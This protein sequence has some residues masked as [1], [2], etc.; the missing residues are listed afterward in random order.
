MEGDSVTVEELKRQLSTVVEHFDREEFL[1]RSQQ[2]RLWKKLKYYWD[3]I[4][5]IYWDSV[6]HDWRFFPEDQYNFN[7]Y[8]EKNVNVFRAYLESII[9]ALSVSVP[10]IICAPDDA[11]NPLDLDTA[12]AGNKIAELVSKHNDVI[13]LWIHALFI[14]CT[15][16]MVACYNYTKEDEA[17]GMVEIPKRETGE[18][19]QKVM[20]CPNCKNDIPDP[21]LTALEKDEYDPGEED[22]DVQNL[23]MND[24]ILCKECLELVDPEY[25]TDKIIV[26]RIVG[27][28]QEP[29]ARQCLEVYGGLYVKVPNWARKQE[30]IPYLIWSYETHY[31][32]VLARYPDLWDKKDGKP[33][34]A[35]SGSSAYDQ[36][37]KWGRQSPQ[38]AGDIPLKDTVTV[39]NCWLRPSAFYILKDNN[40]V[41][42]LEKKFPNGVYV[43]KINDTVVDYRNESLDDHWTLTYNPLSD[44]IHHDPLGMLLT[45]IQ[46]ITSELVNLTIQT[47]EHGIPQTFVDPQVLD[48]NK[49]SQT[50]VQPGSLYPIKKTP[51]SGNIGDAF[52][53]IKTA[54]LSGEVLPFMEKIQEAGQLV[55]GAVPSIFGGQASGGSKTAAVY[56]MSRAQA[57]QRLQT[58]WK[59]LSFWWKNVFS[60]VI[61]AF[62]KDMKDDERFVA[63]DKTGNYLNVFIRKST[64]EAGKIGSIEL[65]ASEQLPATWAQKK[66]VIMQLLQGNNPMVMQALM[67]PE[68]LK[69][70]ADSIGLTDFNLPGEDDRQKQYE[71]IKAL[72]ESEPIIDEQG[73]EV[74]SVNIEEGLDNHQIEA[75]ITRAWLVSDAGR[76]AKIENPKGYKNVLLHLQQHVTFHQQQSMPQPEVEQGGNIP[77]NKNGKAQPIM[78]RPRGNIST[79]Q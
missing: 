1:A 27:V 46:D 43:T 4:H 78:E 17:Y 15:E 37:D 39:K 74:P 44:H 79:V 35:T 21:V 28:T 47:I 49:Y 52:Y 70:L 18:F 8:Y 62:I 53:E 58:P 56:A 59:V 57:L 64:A 66:D 16:G 31:T 63:K 54:T 38:Y 30:D 25:R 34:F 73:Q 26:D 76:L 29:K 6:A 14:Y 42:K 69:L 51:A 41:K 7:E 22:V 32:N 67:D 9:A 20:V 72:M 40:E 60:K 36:D 65:E 75:D 19:D 61:P 48:L 12:K 2:I 23:L 77:T 71:E 3:G 68:N 24:Q 13:L 33:K 50:E 5:N 10:S 45:S 55:S 11:D